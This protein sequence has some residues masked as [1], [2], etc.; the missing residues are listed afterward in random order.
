M[1]RYELQIFSLS[2]YLYNIRRTSGLPGAINYLLVIL[3]KLWEFLTSVTDQTSVLY[4]SA[5]LRPVNQRLPQYHLKLYV[6]YKYVYVFG[7][8]FVDKSSL[9]SIDTGLTMHGDFR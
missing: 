8:V 1:K 4:H 9:K 2:L 5:P 7:F 6:A 3:V